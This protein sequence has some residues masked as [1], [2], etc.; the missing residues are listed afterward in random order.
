[1]C[2]P[3]RYGFPDINRVKIEYRISLFSVL[4]SGFSGLEVL[5]V[6]VSG[7]NVWYRQFFVNVEPCFWKTVARV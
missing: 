6:A 3:R 1:M 7:V 5:N 2:L 4:S